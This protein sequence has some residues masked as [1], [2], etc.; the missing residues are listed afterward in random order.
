MHGMGREDMLRRVEGKWSIAEVLEHLYLTYR[1][2]V[3]GCER[4]LATGKLPTTAPTAKQ[5]FQ[6]LV[7]ITLGYFPHGLQA[8][9]QVHPKGVS[10]EQ[11]VPD[12]G[13]QITHMDEL[14]AQCEQ[15]HGKYS[16]LF[17]HPVM[18]AL[19]GEQWR[20]FHWIHGRHHIRQILELRRKY[21]HKE[22]AP[23]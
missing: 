4:C 19:T 16:K 3:K 1:G 12:I 11:V 6:V 13:Q 22:K 20:K 10:V 14:L 2:T 7:V 17:N 8:P 15:R 18:G 5:R 23:A 9:A 21:T